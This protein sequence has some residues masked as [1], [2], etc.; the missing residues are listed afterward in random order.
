MNLQNC[1]KTIIGDVRDKEKLAKVF[2]EEQP[3]IVIHM[4]AQPIVRESYKNPVYT[5]EVRAGNVIGGGDFAAHRIIPDC[6]RAAVKGENIIIRNPY[7]VRPFQHVLEPVMAYLMIAMK[8]YENPS[9]AGCYNVGPEER[10]CVTTSY[11]ADSF[12]NSWKELTGKDIQWVNQHDGGP[13]EAGFLKLDCSKIKSAFDWKP[14]WGIDYSLQKSI[15]LYL[16]CYEKKGVETCIREQI[17]E[18]VVGSL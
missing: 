14:H 8:Q 7:A 18:Y 9:L 3:E 2:Q 10:D 6:I 12:C 5:Y 15:E 1:M 17:E 11:L 4:A 13:Y 16:K